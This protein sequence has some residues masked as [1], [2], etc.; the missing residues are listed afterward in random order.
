MSS[1][2]RPLPSIN[3][4]GGDAAQQLRHVVEPLRRKSPGFCTAVEIASLMRARLTMHSRRTASLTRRKSASPGPAA[5]RH[6]GS[7]GRQDQAYELVIEA[8]LD[9][10]QHAGD[11]EQR[12]LGGGCRRC[13]QCRQLRD[14]LLHALAQFAQSEHTRACR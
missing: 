7:R 5:D 13:E 1:T 6:F 14:F 9:G 11:F 10:Q 3:K 12:I 8:V 2:A 4:P